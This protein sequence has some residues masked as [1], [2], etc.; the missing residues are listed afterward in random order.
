MR[1]MI[2]LVVAIM[3]TFSLAGCGSDGETKM[4]YVQSQAVVAKESTITQ[5]T[6]KSFAVELTR[7]D[8][9]NI[10][11]L[12]VGG[13]EVKQS[14]IDSAVFT[15]SRFGD[16]KTSPY[17][18][19]VHGSF[20]LVF[21]DLPINDPWVACFIIL[22]SGQEYQVELSKFKK[23]CLK[24]VYFWVDPSS[25]CFEYGDFKSD[26]AQDWIKISVNEATMTAKIMGQFGSD[27]IFGTKAGSFNYK[28]GMRIGVS[29][30]Y[31]NI[32][33]TDLVQDS[34]GNL[35]YEISGMPVVPGPYYSY[36]G[37]TPAPIPT[38]IKDLFI[39]SLNGERI[40]LNTWANTLSNRNE[41][42]YVWYIMSAYENNTP[43][44][45]TFYVE[46]ESGRPME[47]IYEPAW[48]Y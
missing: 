35:S 28:Y 20:R 45:A 36:D 29:D 40:S 5:L 9:G 19:A 2:W 12:R 16:T 11:D 6:P 38:A 21:S 18:V 44:G 17:K 43:N 37:V 32:Y 46:Q 24:G 7:D 33:Y 27:K 34:K 41:S 48:R 39:I 14:E 22:K 25:S 13:I 23:V 4:V 1:K 31:N 3:L 8:N 42:I 30:Q 10:N 26:A 47:I 15:S